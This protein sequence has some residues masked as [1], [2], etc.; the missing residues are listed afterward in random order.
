MSKW[1]KE[2][3]EKY[4][5]IL[6]EASS[7]DEALRII[8]KRFGV[9]LSRHALRR[10]LLSQS[11]ASPADF[12]ASRHQPPA[13]PPEPP[14][15]KLDPELQRL[16][17]A[18]RRKSLTATE[19]CDVLDLSP[20]RLSALIE[21]AQRAGYGVDVSHDHIGLNVTSAQQDEWSLQPK[22]FKTGELQKIGII[23]DIHFGSRYCLR[24]QV[25]QFVVNLHAMGIQDIFCPG[26]LL[27]GCYKHAHFELSAVAWD[28]QAE[29]ALRHLPV[30]PGLKYHFIDGN[31]D[32]TWSDRN[33]YDS[34]KALV[35]LARSYGRE[36]LHYYGARGTL[37]NYGGTR[38]ELWHPKKNLGYAL[39]Y[40]LQNHIRDTHPSRVPDL[41][42]AGHWHRYV[43][44]RQQNTWAFAS[45]TFQHGDSPFGRSLGGDVAVGGL[46]V[47]WKKDSDGVIRHLNDEFHVIDYEVPEITVH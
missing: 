11:N 15:K 16:V 32:Y 44:F 13:P 26:D 29:E 8:Q 5:S 20:K 24:E 12:V 41:L 19:L 14:R 35:S 3:V 40:G 27:E 6:R 7:V 18:V 4:E 25:E 1:S 17:D 9:E 22:N 38:I 46:V 39:S 23:S 42:F 37:I 47:S 43:K 30:L 45:G 33:G 34:G 31:H 36:D 28:D 21:K 2:D 10:A